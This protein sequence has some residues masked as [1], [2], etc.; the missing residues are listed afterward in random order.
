MGSE[1]LT[2]TIWIDGLLDEF[3]RPMLGGLDEFGYPAGAAV[4]VATEIEADAAGMVLG[5]GTTVGRMEHRA[6][7]GLGVIGAEAGPAVVLHERVAV[8]DGC[9]L[10]ASALDAA[11]RVQFAVRA[12]ALMLG[13]GSPTSSAMVSFMAMAGAPS[14][15]L[16]AEQSRI[17]V[18]DWEANAYCMSMCDKDGHLLCF[19]APDAVEYEKEP[20]GPG[21]LKM[22]F[23]THDIA[24]RCLGSFTE[25][26]LYRRGWLWQGVVP[27]S[28]ERRGDEIELKLLTY[29]ALLGRYRAP[30]DWNMGQTQLSDAVEAI[31]EREFITASKSSPSAF[32]AA[33]MENCDVRSTA[34]IPQIMDMGAYMGGI[35]R[36]AMVSFV[37][38]LGEVLKL[39]KLRWRVQYP[40][41]DTTLE[42]SVRTSVDGI[43]WSAP[44]YSLTHFVDRAGTYEQGLSLTGFA[45]TAR[46]VKATLYKYSGGTSPEMLRLY[47]IELVVSK[48]TGLTASHSILESER[49][50]TYYKFD[51]CT[52][53]E[54]LQ[55]LCQDAGYVFSVKPD[56][57]VVIAKPGA[58]GPWV[59]A[60][61]WGVEVRSFREHGLDEISNALL[62]EGHGEGT[63]AL[64]VH[65]EDAGSTERF[66]A[67]RALAANPM[68]ADEEGLE[69]YAAGVLEEMAWPRLELAVTGRVEDRKSKCGR[70]CVIG[71]VAVGD[72]V[73]VVWPGELEYEESPGMVWGGWLYVRREKR[74]WKL[75]A[76]EDV[77]LLMG[78]MPAIEA[79]QITVAQV[80]VPV[81]ADTTAVR[82]TLGGARR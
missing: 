14:L 47:G 3:G 6:F 39:E 74:I 11:G 72:A 26:Y 41:S 33:E 63:G 34:F 81:D 66:G 12:G 28:I 73:A 75:G 15:T 1:H 76:G 21:R 18:E 38:D 56:R 19:L 31:V 46:Y 20:N 43:T 65:A 61:G 40:S 29:E 9:Q 22:T 59:L 50:V 44:I 35:V 16:D 37:W 67:R 32:E 4:V 68:I 55:S 24:A 10:M 36:E 30:R 27:A 57:T 80:P 52:T 58:A 60:E 48:P 71:E 51:N 78:R 53:L 13:L 82:I 70:C 17:R 62:A 5:A 23:S 25:G 2:A 8:A 77:E 69:G 49:L 64:A 54:A 42:V 45:A 79:G 7:A